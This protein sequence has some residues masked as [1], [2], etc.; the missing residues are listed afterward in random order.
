MK[1]ME[2]VREVYGLC[3]LETGPSLQVGF[4]GEQGFRHIDIQLK[5]LCIF[6]YLCNSNAIK[7]SLPF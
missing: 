5:K 6:P 2:H 1:W 7:D 3:S 4:Q